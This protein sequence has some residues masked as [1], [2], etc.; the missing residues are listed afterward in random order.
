MDKQEESKE[1]YLCRR[2]GRKLTSPKSKEQGMGDTCYKKYRSEKNHKIL[3]TMTD[4]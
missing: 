4:K 3:F 1:V 2:C